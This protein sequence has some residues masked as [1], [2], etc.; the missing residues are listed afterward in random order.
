MKYIVKLSY[1]QFIFRDGIDALKFAAT[2]RT[3]AEDDTL[4]VKIELEKEENND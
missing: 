2:A 3:S 1:H 4:D